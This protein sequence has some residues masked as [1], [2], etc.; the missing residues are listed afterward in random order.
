MMSRRI[1]RRVFVGTTLVLFLVVCAG[2]LAA[3]AW[4]A[5]FEGG[6]LRF[7]AYRAVLSESR[8][9]VLLGNSLAISLGTAFASLAVGGSAALALQYCPRFIR[10]TLVV[11]LCIPVLLPPYVFAVAWVDAMIRVG[12]LSPQFLAETVTSHTFGIPSVIFISTFA[13]FPVVLVFTAIALRRFDRR[14][15]EAAR[16]IADPL[17][18]FF[19]VRAPLCAPWVFTGAGFVFLLT[20]TGFSVPALFQ[21]NVY[22]VEIFTELSAFH[23]VGSAVAHMLPL[24]IMGGVVLWAWGAWARP[25]QNWLVPPDRPVGRTSPGWK[26]ASLATGYCLGLVAVSLVIPVAILAARAGTVAQLHA[27]WAGAQPEI[28][29][30][31]AISGLAATL[32]TLLGFAMAYMAHERVRGTGLFRLSAVP[33]LITGPLLGTGLIALWNHAGPPLIVFETLLVLVLACTAKYLYFAYQGERIALEELHPRPLEAAAVYDVGWI[34]RGIGVAAPLSAPALAAIWGM[35]FVFSLRE[36]EA[37]AM[38]APPGITP[39]SIRIHSLMHYGPSAAV[40]SLSLVMAGLL[41][42]A[43]CGTVALYYTCRRVFHA[44]R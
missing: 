43:G 34:R 16:L 15:L 21:V 6:G 25:R 31:L 9:W 24:L 37:A 17:Q 12:L 30:S 11:L 5:L 33:F 41:V 29:T 13:Y 36:L 42:A 28:R 1:S 32:L 14:M 3:L 18:T 10:E 38:V 19:G 8:Q 4:R 20:L 27:A 35:G 39:L 2:P 22:P 44:Y 7:E 23:E 40:A 26:R